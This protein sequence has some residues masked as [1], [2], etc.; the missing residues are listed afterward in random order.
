MNNK[1][2]IQK[3]KTSKIHVIGIAGIEG[4]DIA[5][6]LEKIQAPKENITLHQLFPEKHLKEDFFK[7]NQG[8]PKNELEERYQKLIKSGFTFNFDKN[9]LKDIQAADIIFAPQSW[10]LHESN[11][12]LFQHQEKISTIT[13]LYFQLIPCPIISVTGSNGKSTTTRLIFELINKSSQHK[14]W[15]TGNDRETPSLLLKLDQISPNDFLV[16]E[17]SNRQL[18]FLENHKP[19]ISVITNITENH[20]SEYDNF[21]QYID[22]KLKLF[23]NQTSHDH[24][25]INIDNPT[26]KALDQSDLK[27][28]LHTISL[29]DQNT[30][31]YLENQDFIYKTEKIISTNQINLIG[32]H[33]YQNILQAIVTAKILNIP[34]NEIK[35]TLE[36]FYGLSNRC[37]IVHKS[38]NLTFI[39][40]RQ[41]TSVDST[42]Q[43]LKS[44][45]GPKILIFG[46]EN[47][48][49]ETNTLASYMNLPNTYSIGI[50]SPFVDELKTKL[51]SN[52]FYETKNLTT[53]I[54]VAQQK[55]NQL[56]P[57]QETHIL[58][59][60]ACEYG[61][62]FNPLPGYDD[63]E[64]FNQ[65]VKQY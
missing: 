2:L 21:Q 26:L 11:Q 16:T 37:Q 42:I 15:I 54:Q 3:L 32:P 61:P 57:N 49:M 43:A 13:N 44:I 10:S 5:L 65:I 59:S 20:L 41:G 55:A 17:T 35:T 51:N 1:D 7:Y 6:F 34:N 23:Q 33:N 4:S 27:P 28:Q 56:F 46:G 48:K 40:D 38:N 45:P 18:N 29:N 24:L 31:A 12:I 9:Y 60:P 14:A 47:K 63:A 19:F 8:F 62:Y 36:N 50:Q 64:Q 58:F 25:I 22:T 53:A 39:N 52:N 30:E